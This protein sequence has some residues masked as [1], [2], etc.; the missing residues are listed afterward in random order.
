[1]FLCA[2]SNFSDPISLSTTDYCWLQNIDRA[3]KCLLFQLLLLLFFF[4]RKN[5]RYFTSENVLLFGYFANLSQPASLPLTGGYNY[6]KKNDKRRT[7]GVPKHGLSCSHVQLFS[8]LW[9]GYVRFCFFGWNFEGCFRLLKGA[10]GISKK[11][12]C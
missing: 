1:M 3:Q 4:A 9:K 6:E 8:V 11:M 10:K 5:S 7:V 2:T 12:F